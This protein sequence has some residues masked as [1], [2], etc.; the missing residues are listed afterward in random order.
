M[1][2][3]GTVNIHG[4]HDKKAVLAASRSGVSSMRYGAD[5]GLAS[6]YIYVVGDI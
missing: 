4:M 3:D 5:L 2:S 6:T 1:F